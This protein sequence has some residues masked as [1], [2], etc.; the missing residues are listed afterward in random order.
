[1]AIWAVFFERL[2][3]WFAAYGRYGAFCLV[4]AGAVVALALRVAWAQK[5]G[6]ATDRPEANLHGG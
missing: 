3:E 5:Q 6:D 1:V 4:L 2:N